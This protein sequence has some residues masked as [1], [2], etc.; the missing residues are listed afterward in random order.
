RAAYRAAADEVDDR[1]LEQPDEALHPDAAP[2]KVHQRVEHDLA[3]AM[4]GDVAA[5]VAAH[6]GNAVRHAARGRALPQRI[7]G[8]VLDQPQLV[9][10]FV[11]APAR[12]ASHRLERFLIDHT[13]E[14]LHSTITTDGWS[15]SSR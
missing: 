14:P 2:R 10:R 8:R 4:V 11:A 5:A 12:E 7:D 15:H 3:G 9:G 13:A 1:L 6:H